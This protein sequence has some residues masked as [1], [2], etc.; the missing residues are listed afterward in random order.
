MRSGGWINESFQNHNRGNHCL[1]HIRCMGGN[2]TCIPHFPAKFDNVE[3]RHSNDKRR[4][5]IP[6]T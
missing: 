4:R 6:Q 2:R 5:A 1:R 3:K